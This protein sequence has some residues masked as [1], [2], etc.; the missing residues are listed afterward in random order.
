MEFFYGT[1]VLVV[2]QRTSPSEASIID[3]ADSAVIH[4]VSKRARVLPM[5]NMT[6][7]LTFVS[8]IAGVT[9]S[10]REGYYEVS[11]LRARVTKEFAHDTV[12]NC[13]AVSADGKFLA[14]GGA[15]KG[16]KVWDL[17]SST[18]ICSL[19]EDIY[20]VTGLAFSPSNGN[21]LAIVRGPRLILLEIDKCKT[22]ELRK[23]KELIA[24]VNFN[25]EGT[26]IASHSRNGELV[27]CD[28]GGKVLVEHQVKAKISSM[29]F[30]PSGK[31][32]ALG[33]EDTSIAFWD[34]QKKIVVGTLA[35]HVFRV[36]TMKFNPDGKFLCSG[37]GQD[38]CL[39]N[40][41]SLECVR[42]FVGHKLSMSQIAFSSDGKRVLT[43]NDDGTLKLWNVSSGECLISLSGRK[44]IS[45]RGVAF[46]PDDRTFSCIYFDGIIQVWELFN[47]RPAQKP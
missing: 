13:V 41:K 46:H 26:R 39:W 30:D 37:N 11:K 21:Q 7:I 42:T 29:Q 25:A 10:N 16:V 4:V 23:G 18:E 32:L 17:R 43:S 31:L 14:S 6:T 36:K 38:L 24:G 35:K 1:C 27:V 45:L 15:G 44:N 47:G 2:N 12:A 33:M 22:I 20:S 28:T 5:N 3:Q 8:L 9:N 19:D 34:V 40:V